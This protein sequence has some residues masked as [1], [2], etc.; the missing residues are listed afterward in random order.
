MQSPSS[1]PC[2]LN[3]LCVRHGSD[4]SSNHLWGVHDGVPTSLLLGQLVHHHGCLVDNHLVLIV[5]KLDQLGDGARGQ[6]CIILE[7]TS[8]L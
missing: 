4:Q 2:R 7:K 3:V 6:V 8:T 5:E 1:T